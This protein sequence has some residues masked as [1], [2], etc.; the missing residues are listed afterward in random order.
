MA[1]TPIGKLWLPYVKSA[2]CTL[3]GL[4]DIA[5]R[6]ERG[7]IGTIRLSFVSSVVYSLLPN[8]VANYKKNFPEVELILR[9]ATTD[10]Q[11]RALLDRTIDAGVIIPAIGSTLPSEL[12]SKT[13]RSEPLVA[14]I[15]Q[16]IAR[17]FAIQNEDQNQ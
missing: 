6:L 4:P 9:E 3:E 13:I 7:E 2:I 5:Y 11:I 1:L 8:L 16:D 10:I 12:S 14:A 17:K 15:H